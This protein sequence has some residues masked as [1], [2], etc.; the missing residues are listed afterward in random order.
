M[1]SSAIAAHTMYKMLIFTD[2]FSGPSKADGRVFV[3]LNKNI[4]TN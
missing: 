1:L 2:Q 3:C 4:W